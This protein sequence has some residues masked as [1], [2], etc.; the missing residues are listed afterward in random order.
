LLHCFFGDK[1]PLDFSNDPSVLILTF[2]PVTIRRLTYWEIIADN[3][4]KSGWSWGCASAI[5]SNG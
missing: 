5:D 2:N 3:L 4:S 1:T